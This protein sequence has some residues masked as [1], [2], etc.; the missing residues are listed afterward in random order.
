MEDGMAEAS[1]FQ[2]G[3]IVAYIV[4]QG[5]ELEAGIYLR[6]EG[7]KHVVWARIHDSGPFMEMEW[8]NV[9]P[10]TAWNATQK[11]NPATAQERERLL[12]A[13]SAEPLTDGSRRGR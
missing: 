3:D 2:R 1:E 6:R 5:P 4:G 13:T 7:G 9:W 12:E 11:V 8:G 10:H